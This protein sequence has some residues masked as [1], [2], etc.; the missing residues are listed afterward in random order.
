MLDV[1]G[2]DDGRFLRHEDPCT[3][4]SLVDSNHSR[5]PA[6]VLRRGLGYLSIDQKESDILLTALC[7]NAEHRVSLA[8]VGHG[9]LGSPIPSLKSRK[10]SAAKLLVSY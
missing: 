3:N 10:A 4:L 7:R 1:E 2:A 9:V 5:T 8:H 6:G